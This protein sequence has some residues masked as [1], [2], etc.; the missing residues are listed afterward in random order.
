MEMSKEL[1][2]FLEDMKAD[3][4]LYRKL[5]EIGRR[6]MIAGSKESGNELMAK[7]AAELGYSVT[8]AEL[9]RAEAA[10]EE[11]DD[12][13]LE[14]VCGGA[15]NDS[16]SGCLTDCKVNFACTST[17]NKPNSAGYYEQCRRYPYDDSGLTYLDHNLK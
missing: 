9:E 17:T 1:Q 3:R 15:N 4:E 16:G 12:N 11:V 8:A 7:A 2:R 10:A 5:E 13:Q 14:G 6:M